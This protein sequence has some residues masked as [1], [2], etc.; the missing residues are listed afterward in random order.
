MVGG[1]MSSRECNRRDWGSGEVKELVSLK[2]V[3]IRMKVSV[4][5]DDLGAELLVTWM[6]SYLIDF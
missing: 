4:L 2:Y 6:G 1:R 5:E 3:H